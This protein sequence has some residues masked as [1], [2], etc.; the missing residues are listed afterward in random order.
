VPKKAIDSRAADIKAL[1]SAI[2][3][4][5]KFL[6]DKPAE[7]QK[8]VAKYLGVKPEEVKGMLDGDKIYSLGDNAK[9]LIEDGSGFAS[10]KR[11]IDFA[12]SQKLIDKPIDPKTQIETKFVKP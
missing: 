9:L 7:A 5:V 3:Q 8:I 1:L 6:R 4:G 12:T 10:M 11:V 2:D